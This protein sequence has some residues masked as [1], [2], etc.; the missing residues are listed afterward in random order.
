MPDFFKGSPF[1]KSKDGN[2]DELKK[3]FDTTSVAADYSASAS[4][5]TLASIVPT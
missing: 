4:G 5:L 1:P 2:K 3:F